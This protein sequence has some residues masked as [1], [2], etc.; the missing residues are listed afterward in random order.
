MWEPVTNVLNNCTTK[1]KWSSDPR[2]PYAYAFWL[3]ALIFIS[4]Y[5]WQIK[6]PTLDTATVVFLYNIVTFSW[7]S[8]KYK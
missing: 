5:Q 7:T 8:F 3:G 4:G 6:G 2:N 1:G